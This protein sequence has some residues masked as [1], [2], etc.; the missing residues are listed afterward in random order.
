MKTK[1]VQLNIKLALAKTGETY[2]ELATSARVS[3][4]KIGRVVR[5]TGTFTADELF[6][7]AAHFGVTT[8]W[9]HVEQLP[10]IKGK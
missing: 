4:Y 6:R 10:E 2:G 7:I 8:D 3:A 1:T 9:F 5:G